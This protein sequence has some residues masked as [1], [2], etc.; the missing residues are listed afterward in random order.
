MFDDSTIKG[1]R[2]SQLKGNVRNAKVLAEK[3]TTLKKHVALKL[4][5]TGAAGFHEKRGTI[6]GAVKFRLETGVS[7]GVT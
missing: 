2:V 1:L 6:K 5:E 4:S 3:L 7:A